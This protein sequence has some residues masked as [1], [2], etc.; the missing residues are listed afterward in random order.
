L[1]GKTT[2]LAGGQFTGSNAVRRI[3]LQANFT[4]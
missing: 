3:T 2:G 1:F 4:F